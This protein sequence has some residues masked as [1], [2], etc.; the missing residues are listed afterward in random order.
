MFRFVHIRARMQIYLTS[1][2]AAVRLRKRKTGARRRSAWVGRGGRRGHV[3][4]ALL[5]GRAGA[6]ADG[7]SASRSVD[8]RVGIFGGIHAELF[9]CPRHTD[10]LYKKKACV[11]A[12]TDGYV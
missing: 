11:F 8:A 1:L 12:I 3:R 6:R 7:L 2:R 9:S 4:Q 10:I 5:P